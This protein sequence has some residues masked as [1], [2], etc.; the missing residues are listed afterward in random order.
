VKNP[1]GNF[2][3]SSFGVIDC[4]P[5]G[6]TIKAENYSFLL[7]QLKGILTEKSGGI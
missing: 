1:T 5:K 2:L 4:L 6:H 3:P 7:V